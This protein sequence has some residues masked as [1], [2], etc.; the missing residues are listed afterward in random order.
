MLRLA[1]AG[2]GPYSFLGGF[3]GWYYLRFLDK[4]SDGTVG[5]FSDDFGFVVL[6]PN[7]TSYVKYLFR[8]LSTFH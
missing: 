3:F 5:D 2:A 4:K 6:V 1:L 8:T 7:W